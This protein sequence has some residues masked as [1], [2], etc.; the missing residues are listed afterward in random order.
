MLQVTKFL[1][2]RSPNE[3]R[4]DE[5]HNEVLKRRGKETTSN[6]KDKKAQ[7][8]KVEQIGSTKDINQIGK[9]PNKHVEMFRLK[10]VI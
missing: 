5:T 3:T 9:Q 1:V 4:V 7:R 2:I 10:K 8:R 6:V